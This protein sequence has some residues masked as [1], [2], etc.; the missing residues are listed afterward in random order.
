MLKQEEE[1]I[2]AGIQAGKKSE[3]I[4]QAL[5]RFN[6]GYVPLV[7]E[8]IDTTSDVQETIT[9]LKET[10]ERGIE[11]I[12]EISRAEQSG[13]QGALRS[14]FQ[15]FG[16]GAS[17][18]ARLAG[19]LIVGF[20]KGLI[21]QE[22]EEKIGE[23]IQT[24]AQK[25]A[26][27]EPVQ[28]LISRYEQLKIENPVLARDIEATLGIGELATTFLG[29]GTGS[30]AAQAGTRLIKEVT[31]TALGK[32]IQALEGVTEIGLQ[33]VKS[34]T[35]KGLDPANIMQ[36]VARIS[37]SKQAEFQN[38]AGEGVGQYLVSRGIFGT[39]DEISTQLYKRFSDSKGRVDDALAGLPGIFK[40]VP[41]GN[42]LKQLLA[43]EQRIS[44]PGAVSKDLERV[45]I[46]NKKHNGGGLDMSEINEV[47][48]LYERNVKLDFLKE[49]VPDKVELAN[50]LDNAIRTWQQSKASELGF[51]NIKELNKE[52]RLAKQLLDDIGKE[53]A[54][55]AGNNAITITDWILLAG[56][57]PT[58]LGGF[59]VKKT[60][61]S[62]GVQSAVAKRLASEPTK[63]LPEAEFATPTVDN[64]LNFLKKTDGVSKPET[65]NVPI[66][67]ETNQ[68]LLSEARKYKSA[69]DFV[70]TIRKA[71]PEGQAETKRVNLIRDLEKISKP[72]DGW[73]D[74]AIDIW[75][76][77]NKSKTD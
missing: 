27:L 40:T 25:I 39:I 75:N 74:T 57:D 3:E 62:K 66:S 11:R 46:L 20:G 48:R 15:R 18:A 56:G 2:R 12:D 55:S 1:I 61:S 34:A 77:A 6:T 43:R 69:E 54:G 67:K 16:V 70:E 35:S 17:T 33:G 24:G 36:R 14:M 47:K 60:L 45:R 4:R 38:T 9:A 59:L 71:L 72:K 31:K 30:L 26:G 10:G 8:A 7:K 22:T 58:A 32:S 73:L 76:K 44:S 28:N 64:Y 19:D 63:K 50:N 5:I 23:T 68:N 42:A 37:K 29:A 41:V 13:E 52:T 49:N 65:K 21:G 51:K 53:Y